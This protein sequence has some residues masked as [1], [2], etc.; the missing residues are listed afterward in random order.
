VSA[1]ALRALSL[2]GFSPLGVV[3]G[4][5]SVHL[6]RPVTLGAKSRLTAFGRGWSGDSPEDGVPSAIRTAQGD[7]TGFVASFPCPHGR[8]RVVR[9]TSGHYTGFNFEVPGPGLSLGQIFDGALFRLITSAAER[10]AHGVI[11]VA[12]RLD[13]DPMLHGMVALTLTGTAVAHQS[14][15]APKHLFTATLGAQALVKLLGEGLFPTTISFGAV[16][17][18][19][20]TGCAAR[21]QLD[22]GFSTQVDQLGALLTQA[23][24]LATTRMAAGCT[25]ADAVLDTHLTHTFHQSTKSDYRVAAW[26]SGTGTRRFA[27]PEPSDP[28]IPVLTMEQ[29]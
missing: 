18:D 4:N 15:P 22:S 9:R 25:A 29:R 7:A 8:G 6:A 26:A 19:A 20:W 17:L 3:F 14:A 24:D 13:G 10:G 12:V 16:L 27:E 1:A 23:R 21:V 5:A 28:A 11:D 2:A